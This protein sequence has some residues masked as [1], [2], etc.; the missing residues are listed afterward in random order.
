M[1][2]A[3]TDRRILAAN[4]FESRKRLLE[5]VSAWTTNG[6]AFIQL[7][8]KDLPAR[9]LVELARAMLQVIRAS[10]ASRTRLL[11]NGRADVALAA[12]ADGVHLPAAHG[13]LTPTEVRSIFTSAGRAIPPAI[14]I[15]CHTLQEVK[16]VR[17]ENPDCILFAPI[18]EKRISAKEICSGTGLELLYQ[19]CRLAAPFPVF[20]LGGITSENAADCLRAGASGIAAIRLLQQPP[21]IWR[22]LA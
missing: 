11:I 17:R 19:A 5:L 21:S 14:S 16:T 22:H 3:I 6:V 12:N 15:S 4:E 1:L 7:R 13:T 9:D 18:F 2:Y 10:D 8:E 20:A